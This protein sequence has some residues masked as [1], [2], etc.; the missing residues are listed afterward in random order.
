MVHRSDGSGT[1]FAWT[2]YLSKVNPE[3]K[4]AVGSGTT[5]NWPV[6]TGAECNEGVADAVH[7]TPNS[8]GYIEFIYALQHELNFAHVQNSS[9]NY[10]KANLDSVTAAANPPGGAAMIFVCQ[11]PTPRA[12][13]STQFRR[14]RGC[15]SLPISAMP[16]K[17]RRCVTCSAG[18]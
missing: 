14:S 7:K 4:S 10:I 3:W 9:G 15:L 1:T 17:K 5:V 11:S 2:D 18:C 16:P 12:N 6:G 13:M 8:I